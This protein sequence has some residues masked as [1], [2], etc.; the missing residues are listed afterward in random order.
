MIASRKV[1]GSSAGPWFGSGICIERDDT[2]GIGARL[3]RLEEALLPI[4][5]KGHGF[6]HAVRSL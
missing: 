6:S 4:V 2:P 3:F 1:H 5:L